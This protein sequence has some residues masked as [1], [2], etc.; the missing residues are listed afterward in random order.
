M[1]KHLWKTGPEILSLARH[2]KLDQAAQSLGIN[3]TTL[4]RKVN[5]LEIELGSKLFIPD[6]G[7]YLLTEKGVDIVNLLEQA[8]CI[9]SRTPDTDVENDTQEIPQIKMSLPPHILPLVDSSIA[10]ILEVTAS[11]EIDLH[12]SYSVVDMRFKEYDIALRISFTPP[13]YPLIPV[14]AMDLLGCYCSARKPD[15]QN[16][17]FVLN[18]FESE[19]APWLTNK[20][21]Q[22]PIIQCHDYA[23]QLQMLAQNGV[24]RTILQLAENHTEI[25]VLRLVEKHLG[26]KL[27]VVNHA[28]TRFNK[29]V[30]TATDLL[31]EALR[32]FEQ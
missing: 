20:F 14:Y 18:Q 1:E 23:S 9:L 13:R 19:P 8:E 28:A 26:Y 21:G 30:K 31:I 16:T 27:F 25:Q 7:E 4:Q 5:A 2:K 24:G 29:G 10:R 3:R 17:Y 15:K 6:R 22:L 32:Q 11:Q 12:V